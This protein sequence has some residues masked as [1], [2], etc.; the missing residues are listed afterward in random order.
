[1]SLRNSIGLIA[2][3]GFLALSSISA[4]AAVIDFETVP[5]GAATVI[6]Q[7]V[8]NDYA[9]LGLTFD[10]AYYF[11]CPGTCPAPSTG[12]FVSGFKTAKGFTAT[13]AT[14]QDF[15]SFNNIGGAS[16]I[17]YYAYDGANVL[18]G[19]GSAGLFP[20]P[21]IL[22]FTGMKS[23]LFAPD[24]PNHL[25]VNYGGVDNFSFGRTNGAVPEPASWA[26]MIS[27]FGL[28]G[29]VL[30]RRRGLAALTA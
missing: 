14:A 24:A 28:A 5:G 21:T 19:S 25:G 23:V 11:R 15:F 8:N 1:M 4:R 3:T 18:L 26:L 27:G 20:S 6:G 13:F 7:L 2:A 22:T 12:T 9:A 30:R 16:L 17:Q 10:S 29:A